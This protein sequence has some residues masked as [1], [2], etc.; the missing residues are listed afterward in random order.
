MET[1]GSLRPVNQN[2]SLE[3]HPEPGTLDLVGD[4]SG[5]DHPAGA[6]VNEGISASSID[7]PAIANDSLEVIASDAVSYGQIGIYSIATRVMQRRRDSAALQAKRLS[8]STELAEIPYARYREFRA[9]DPEVRRRGETLAEYRHR[10][11]NDAPSSVQGEIPTVLDAGTKQRIKADLKTDE[12]LRKTYLEASKRRR[13]TVKAQKAA[14]FGKTMRSSGEDLKASA[15][16]WAIHKKIKG[17]ARKIKGGLVVR[18]ANRSERRNDN[19]RVQA[20]AIE[21]LKGRAYKTRR[22]GE[23]THQLIEQLRSREQNARAN[24]NQTGAITPPPSEPSLEPARN[25]PSRPSRQHVEPADRARTRRARTEWGKKWQEQQAR[26]R[27]G[28]V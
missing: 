8:R 2:L 4:A 22:L 21:K 14:D 19:T 17:S 23:K 9:D 13:R 24:F 1:S 6:S 18:A 28:V 3:S 26:N 11:G 12:K 10:T 16:P 20:E 27:A 25:Y 5:I 7:N 15:K